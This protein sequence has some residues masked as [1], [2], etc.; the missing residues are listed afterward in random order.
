MLMAKIYLSPSDQTENIYAC[1]GTN[2]AEQCRKIANAC[3]AALKRC[4]FDVKNRQN[5]SYVD[6]TNESNAWDADLHLCIHTNA[7]NGKTDGLRMFYY[8]EGGQS[9]KACKSIYDVLVKIVPGTSSNM[10]A[11]QE[12]Y[13][14]YYTNCASV[15]CEVSFHDV[16]STSQWIVS[17]TNEIADAIVRGICN[18]YG[19]TYKVN[20]S[21][22]SSGSIYQVV[23]GSFK[24]REN[25]E[26]R[27]K[28]LKSKGFDSFIQIR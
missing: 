11:N 17:H 26:K 21:D 20:T 16:Y 19:V 1:G 18:F 22:V 24:V 4:R 8:D 2:E 6:R 23:T 14:M 28:E 7:F 27:A 5:G 15:Y 12:L 25:A 13:E 9:Y 10:R 3:E